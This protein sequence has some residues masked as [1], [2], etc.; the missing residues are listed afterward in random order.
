MI[1]EHK[2]PKRNSESARLQNE[3][4]IDG[5]GMRP[6]GTGSGYAYFNTT[7]G[8]QRVKAVPG[9]TNNQAE[10]RGLLYALHNL[11]VGS[12]AKI[13]GDS[14]L[15]VCQFNGQWA[16]ND[17]SLRALLNRAREIIQKRRLTITLGW[18]PRNQNLAGKLIES[19]HLMGPACEE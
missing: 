5:G 6:D 4:Y 18:V 12:E 16:V 19:R 14:Q 2:Q 1:G 8:E 15:V 17:S 3:V 13:F 11:P 7:T 10:F 9:L